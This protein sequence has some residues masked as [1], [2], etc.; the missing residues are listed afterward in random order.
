MRCIEE[1]GKDGPLVHTAT[2]VSGVEL[3]HRATAAA[4][5]CLTVDAAAADSFLQ[6]HSPNSRGFTNFFFQHG[7]LQLWTTILY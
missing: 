4:C 7:F 2:A 5:A 6:N 3:R 1:T